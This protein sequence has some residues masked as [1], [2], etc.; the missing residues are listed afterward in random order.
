MGVTKISDEELRKDL[1]AGLT[2]KEIVEKRGVTIQTVNRKMKSLG[3]REKRTRTKGEWAEDCF[4]RDRFNGICSCLD[5]EKCPGKSCPF[6]KEAGEA[7]E[8]M[9]RGTDPCGVYRKNT[10]EVIAM[11]ERNQGIGI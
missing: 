3:L 9:R 5:V 6:Y 10:L 11:I 7:L 4:A 8:E 2:K 1:E